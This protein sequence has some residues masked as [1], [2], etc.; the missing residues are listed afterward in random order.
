[1]SMDERWVKGTR[2]DT[3]QGVWVNMRFA[4]VVFVDGGGI[5]SV[6]NW[7]FK[8]PPEHF[9]PKSESP[10]STEDED[11][12]AAREAYEVVREFGQPKW[13]EMQGSWRD[14]MLRLVTEARKVG[15]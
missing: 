7:R 15:R 6:G 13:E 1:M 14:M 8:E 10:P 2:A 11:V 4:E 3:G 9:L 12:R 5:T